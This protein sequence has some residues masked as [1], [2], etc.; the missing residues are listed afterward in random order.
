[1]TPDGL[2]ALLPSARVGDAAGRP[3]ADVPREQWLS[4]ARALRD[5]GYEGYDLLTAV[6]E[7]E[8]GVDVVLHVWSV[9]DGTSVLLR[10]RCPADDLSV[11]SLS[12]LFAGAAWHEREV[13]EMFGLDVP[14]HPGLV[15][16]LLPDGFVGAPLRKEF[17]LATR[18]AIP[19]PGAPEPGQST[20][21]AAAGRRRTLP[22]GVPRPGTWPVAREDR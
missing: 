16:L 15:P 11:P 12:G 5:A 3:V 21:E 18:V 10:T 6:D 8:A 1:M 14:G 17:V 2:A 13:A 22:P 4:A 7:Q 19:W 9:R 20:A